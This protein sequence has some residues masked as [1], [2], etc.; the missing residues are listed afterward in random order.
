MPDFILYAIVAGLAL[1]VVAGPL[2]SFVVWRKMAYFGDTLSHAS[3]LG[4]ALGFVLKINL[5]FAIIICCILVAI[6]LVSL[7][8]KQPLASDTLLGILAH[9]TLSLGLVVLSFMPDV[10]VNLMDYLFGDILTITASDLYWIVGGSSFVLLLII[11]LWQQLLSITVHEELAAVEGLPV[12]AIRLALM[13]MV[14]IVIA[15]TMKIVGVLLIA[16]LLV[17][18]PATAR[19]HTASPEQMAISASILGMLSICLGLAFSYYS[20]APA[21][22]AIV[23]STAMLFIVSF[24]F[25]RKS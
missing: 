5:T 14:A 3:L 16:S 18:P 15:V 21:G 7:Q 9:S 10:K 4:V 25:R 6:L 19:F 2:G 24:I 23:L 12:T 8:R 1:A 13:L 11:L 20:N 17:I 22:P